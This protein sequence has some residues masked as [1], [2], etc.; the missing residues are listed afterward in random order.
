MS[1]IRLPLQETADFRS[2]DSSKDSIMYNGFVEIESEEAR[3]S[4]KRAGSIQKIIGAG[5]AGGIFVYG[6]NLYS[7]DSSDGATVP[8]VTLL[9]SL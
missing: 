7:W 8:V 1:R 6:T 4:K 3:Y 9:S 2:S 5:T